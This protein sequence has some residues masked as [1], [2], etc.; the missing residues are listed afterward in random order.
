[1]NADAV[2]RLRLESELRRALRRG[3]AARSTTSPSWTS[4]PGEIAGCEALA[5]LAAPRTRPGLAGGVHPARRADRPDRRPS[6]PWVLREACA[7]ATAWQSVGRSGAARGRQPLGAPVPP[8]G[9]RP[10]RGRSAARRAGLEASLRWSSRSP[11]ACHAEPGSRPSTCCDALK[12]AGRARLHRRLRHRL[13]VAQLPPALPHRHPQDRPLVRAR[14]Q[15]RPRATP[16]SRPRSWPWPRPS[17]CDVVAEGVEEERSSTC[18]A[19][20]IATS[21]RAISSVPPSGPTGCAL[22][23]RAASCRPSARASLGPAASEG[24]RRVRPL[25]AALAW[26]V[27]RSSLVIYT[28]HPWKERPSRRGARTCRAH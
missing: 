17:A 11:R 5:A 24:W 26:W 25:R 7:Q 1:M 2:E 22:R 18:C 23:S 10:A 21:P 19:S 13:L 16:P 9:P 14:H 8:R 3:R 27:P 15:H 12:R 4:R 20:S 6:G 28:V